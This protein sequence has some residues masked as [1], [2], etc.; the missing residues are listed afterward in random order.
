MGITRIVL[1]LWLACVQGAA[2]AGEVLVVSG[3]PGYPPVTW[4]ENGV[5]VGVG[6]EL[7]KAVFTELKVPYEI[8]ADGRWIRVQKDAEAGVIDVIAGVYLNTERKAFL[9][10]TVPF[11]KDPNVVFVWKGKTFPFNT[12]DDL[13]GKRGTTN[14]GE[15]FEDKFD[16]F[17]E[18]KLSLERVPETIQNLKKLESGRA[19]YFVFGLYPGLSI[20]TL[21]GYDD[22][23]E[24][25]PKPILTANFYMAFS[26][27]S[28][29]VH[30]LPKVNR[31]INRLKAEGTV[32]RWLKEQMD[33]YRRLHRKP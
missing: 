4:E 29:Y 27:K 7:V 5:I 26:K 24:A 6:A 3:H 18:A 13:I 22:K 17:A 21:E 25:L 30:L 14:I 12:W 28:K 23:I 11:M 16:H 33:D 15:S 10:Y 8:R 20:A 9:E 1:T 32:D 31:I 19:D 2:L